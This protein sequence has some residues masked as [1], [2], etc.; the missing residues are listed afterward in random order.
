M[1]SLRAA[2]AARRREFATVRRCAR[3]SLAAL[4]IPPMP[5][6]PGE[7]G[8][9]LWPRGT[10]GSM[11]HCLGYRAAAAARADEITAL[12]ID[13]EPHQPPFPLTH[14]RLDFR[15]ASV[16]FQPAE[17]TFSAEFLVPGPR[18]GEDE[19]SRFHGRWLVD[20][21]IVLT[22]IAL[23]PARPNLRQVAR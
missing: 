23:L 4:G 7:R 11:T 22:A 3:Q 19:V 12:G 8:A 14:R 18:I 10:V 13:A 6:L 15:T 2:V 16:S 17:R 20:Q 5:L 21:G 1:A 9:P